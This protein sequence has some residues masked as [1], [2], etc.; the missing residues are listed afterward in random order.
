[1][2]AAVCELRIVLLGKNESETSPVGNAILGT[3]AFH[4]KAPSYSQQY[5]MR[6]RGDV[7]GRHITVIN[8]HLLQPDLSK[9]QVTQGVRECVSLSAPG[10]HV[11]VLVLQYKD[12][13]EN[14]R[15]RVKYVLNL[16][17][18][19]ALNHTIVL[20]TDEEPRT[21]KLTSILWNKAIHDLIKECGGRHLK[22]DTG[23]VGW[24]SEL[25]RRTEEILKKEHE[26]FL[27]GNMYE[28]EGNGSS[29]D[30][31]PSKS[32]MTSGKAKLN[33]VLCGY[34]TTLK[35]SVSEMFRGTI[36]QTERSN[37][38]VKNEEMINE[39]QISVIELPA[40]TQLSEEEVMH[41]T[42][43]CVSLC[44]P[45]VHVFILIIPDAPL[46]NEDRAEIEEIQR[47]FSS[48]IN[49]HIMILI[50]QNSEHQTAELNEETQSVIQRFGGRH[51]FIDLNTQVSV[52]MEKL[53]QMVEENSGVCF[54]TVTL[55]EAHL[56]LDLREREDDLRIVL[57]G[58]TGVG[59]SS[60]GNIILGKDT[61]KAE[62]CPVSVTKNCQKVTAEIDGRHITVIDTPGLF[63]TKRSNEEIQREIS[64]CIPM[65][66]PGPHVFLLMISVGR[67]TEEEQ[68]AV[69]IIQ[70]IFGESSLKY[71]I[72]LFTRGDDLKNKTIEQYLL[73]PTP[74]L[75]K[76]IESCGNRFHVFN[77]K[78]TED[79]TQVTDLLQKI[80]N[81][82]KANGDS[83]Y[84][85]KMFRE[86]ERQKQDRQMKILIE[87][88]EQ[89]NREREELIN[90]HKEEK[91]R[92]KIMMEKEKQNHDKENDNWRNEKQA[93]RDEHNQK[94]QQEIERSQKVR[95]DLQT[96]H[97]EERER[98]KKR[99]EE[100]R[101]N[102][103]KERERTK[104]ELIKRE[105]QY[106][107]SI[108]E[109]EEQEKKLREEQKGEREEWEKQKQQER[110][111][112]EE[113]EE[114]W[115]KKEQAMWDEH[116]QKL[117][118]ERK[119]SQ[120]ERE[121]LQLKNEE[122]KKKMEML[123]EEERNNHEKYRK[124]REE[125]FRESEERYKTEMKSERE[126]WEKQKKEARQRRGE[127][128]ERRRIMEQRTWD[129]YCQNLKQ[130]KERMKKIME[131]E[132]QNLDKQRQRREEEHLKSEE[133]YKRDIK[134]K[135]EQERQIREE[136]KSE[137]EE[138][139]KRKRQEEKERKRHSLIEPYTGT[140]KSLHTNNDKVSPSDSGC[141]RILLLGRTGSGKSATGNT[142]LGKNEFHSIDSSELVTTVCQKRVGEVDGRSV[143]VIDTP[144]LDAT[145]T[146][147]KVLEEIMNCI[148]LSA[149]GP[150]AI[151][152]VLNLGKI[153][154]EEK[155]TLDMIKMLFG[156]KAADFCIVLFNR[157]DYLPTEF[158]L[159]HLITGQLRRQTIQQYLEENKNVE[160]KKL[161]S[162]C[163]NRFL[164]FN[165][166]ETEDKTQVTHL[167][168]MIEKMN[169][170]RHFTNEM[171]EEA[172]ISIEKGMEIIDMNE[173][174][175][176]DQVKELEAKYD[177]EDAI[178][179]MR[180]E[181]KK[182]KIDEERERL[183]NKLREQ[184]E[185]LRRE[186][187]NKKKLEQEQ[188]KM[189]DQKRSEEEEQERAEYDQI[190][191]EEKR[192]IEDKIK[193]YEKQLRESE[194]E[195]RKRGEEY[196]RE[197]EDMNNDH[198]HI[199][200]ELR[201][202]Y[203]DEIKIRDSDEQTR[204]EK[205][206]KERE[207]WKRKIK[208]AE[209][210]KETQEKIKRQQREWE[211]EKK[212]QMRK[213]E[214]E[215]RER[216]ET[217][218]KQLREKQEK[219]EKIQ[220][221]FETKREEDEQ[222][223]EDEREKL[224]RDTEKKKKDHEEKINEMERRY[225]QLKRE[226]KEERK[227]GKRE[228][229]ERLVEKRKR[230]EKMI[231]DIRREQEEEIRRRERE[232]RKRIDREEKECDEMKQKLK[233]EIAKLKK[234]HED[235]AGNQREELN[236]FR[237]RK[238]QHIQE[239]KD[240]LEEFQKQLNEV[241]RLRQELEDKCNVM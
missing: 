156:P 30:E 160:I 35:N 197:Q 81:M 116:N 152:I 233:E 78:E 124:K 56:G 216:Q 129:E 86:M 143:A 18:E 14:K 123:M 8:T 172:A 106:K 85:C 12:F 147:E 87:K 193:Q 32:V 20:T 144:G 29:V 211:E 192:K 142:I 186:F 236:D 52:L 167:F 175:N 97:E 217:H 171:F 222:K 39:W 117:E 189:E 74:A 40:L 16:F 234:K 50:K 68:T 75:K 22:F 47:I 88:V 122:E 228:D 201:N 96:K 133:Q 140:L 225:E 218:E 235:E 139:E 239:L 115:R 159:I 210:D 118:E 98:M 163:G 203:E 169:H 196:K 161:T 120:K 180:L 17:S 102:H 119:R 61:F 199:M 44:D 33:I 6:I 67:F 182:Q 79:R 121:D 101:Q 126:E 72:V 23:N 198:E 89:V 64:N 62:A 112:R 127:E 66:L 25:F 90:K 173:R 48:R 110:R 83:Y 191:R 200:A 95:E 24:Q 46:N 21:S 41:E 59:K 209:N 80:D 57:L 194:E 146:K 162:D 26:K 205:G 36:K 206:E 202:K 148:S 150:H 220:K 238:E 109:K 207:E 71:T 4:S 2:A 49:K 84:S 195:D 105:E 179:R 223:K 214:K 107:K 58:K 168:S 138:W 185:T 241:K 73:Q 108:I 208:E 190:I 219:L 34:N 149:P 170:G 5:S 27:I 55:F 69:K 93:M 7:E 166:T 132:R 176:Q 60:T 37:V 136:M 224:K 63:D 10:P 154:K 181:E 141:L 164:V 178:I 237:K 215:E 134:E 53:E 184:E 231:E 13:N 9:Q 19:Q 221:E 28:D 111:R 76:L 130:E 11:F 157:E 3:A 70:D 42:H 45:G 100:E 92:I 158:N 229:E 226:R 128:E 51:Q 15:H 230:W 174:Q 103:D 77:N 131:E 113:E 183:K 240:R 227:R 54:S 65:I 137:R 187:E 188:Q 213:Q 165:N 212:R 104:V 232:E 82:V 204:K 135:E 145:L 155:H 99:M 38:F 153:T 91:K 43:H 125:E 1:M 177:M 114:K 94:L 31:D 151:I